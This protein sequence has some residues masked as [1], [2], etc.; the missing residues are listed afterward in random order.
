MH[1]P[2]WQMQLDTSTPNPYRQSVHEVQRLANISAHV[3]L[4]LCAE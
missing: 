1:A 2:A 3:W 4:E